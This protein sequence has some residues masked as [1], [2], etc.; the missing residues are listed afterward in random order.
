MLKVRSIFILNHC[1]FQMLLIRKNS[2][3]G[4]RTKGDGNFPINR[5]VE[6]T[7]NLFLFSTRHV[8]LVTLQLSLWT[9]V[10]DICVG[11][12]IPSILMDSPGSRGWGFPAKLGRFERTQRPLPCWESRRSPSPWLAVFS[13]FICFTVRLPL[14]THS[15]KPVW[16]IFIF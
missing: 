4:I 5:N 11:G 1:W 3:G 10:E 14:Q 8:L 9:S 7:S 6:S 12:D 15:S 16:S 13:S 2:C